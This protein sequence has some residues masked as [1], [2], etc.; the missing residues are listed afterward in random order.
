MNL[1]RST[2][3]TAS[4]EVRRSMS[5]QRLMVASVLAG[6]PPAM[7]AVIGLSGGGV[8]LTD[9]LIIVLVGIVGLLAQLLW[10]TSNV[11]TELEGKSWIF[12]ASRPRGRISLFLGKYVSAVAFS[13]AVCFVAITLSIVFRTYL[14]TTE[15]N[16]IRNWIGMIGSS[17]LACMVYSAIFSVIG[18]IFQKR[19]MVFAAGYIIMSEMILANVPAIIGRFTA[20]FHLQ[21]VA[22]EWIGWFHPV[23]EDAFEQLFGKASQWFHL[24]CLGGAVVALLIIGCVVITTREYITAEEA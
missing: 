10:A 15:I 19:A 13:F 8:P 16:P 18:T 3:A 11:F 5:M 24:S 4:F 23:P 2:W 22:A 17:L 6:F 12:L 14:L 9:L 21:A 1:L 7:V 20:R